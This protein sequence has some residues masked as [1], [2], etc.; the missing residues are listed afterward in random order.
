MLLSRTCIFLLII[1]SVITDDITKNTTF[2]YK[3]LA[4]SHQT[5]AAKSDSRRQNAPER[6]GDANAEAD[7]KRKEKEDK[8]NQ[9]SV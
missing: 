8:K 9:E 6:K 7:K 3:T 4:A 5:L 2:G 1:S